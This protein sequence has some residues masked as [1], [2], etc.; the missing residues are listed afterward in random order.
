M[1]DYQNQP[2]ENGQPPSIAMG[3]GGSGRSEPQGSMTANLIIGG[4]LVGMMAI[5]IA[6]AHHHHR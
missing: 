5:E 6:S 2:G 3:G 4:I 1:S